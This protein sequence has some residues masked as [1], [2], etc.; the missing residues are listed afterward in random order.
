MA[1]VKICNLDAIAPIQKRKLILNG[2]EYEV[3]P[4]SVKKFI[5]FAQIRQKINADASLNEGLDLAREMIKSAIPSMPPEVM[6][7]MTIPH[8]QLI[9]AFINDEIPED[10]LN[11]ETSKKNNK[12]VKAKE[13]GANAEDKSGN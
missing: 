7:A 6:D 8:L 11:G 2:Q 3:E 9:I 4:L 13:E 10:V 1:D 12:K 5:E